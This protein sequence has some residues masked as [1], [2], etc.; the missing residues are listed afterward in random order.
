MANV[1]IY[2]MKE[3]KGNKLIESKTFHFVVWKNGA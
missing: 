2:L 3:K 1:A